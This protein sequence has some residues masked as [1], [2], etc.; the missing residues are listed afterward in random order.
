[1]DNHLAF[2]GGF[3]GIAV[4]KYEMLGTVKIVKDE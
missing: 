2:S 3:R 4:A 1:L